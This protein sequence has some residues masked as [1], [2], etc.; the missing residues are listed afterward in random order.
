MSFPLAQNFHPAARRS[1]IVIRAPLGAVNNQWDDAMMKSGAR[2]AAPFELLRVSPRRIQRAASGH[3]PHPGVEARHGR[4]SAGAPS[5]SPARLRNGRK[6]RLLRPPPG[7]NRSGL[8][9]VRRP[10]RKTLTAPARDPTGPCGQ[11]PTD[12]VAGLAKR[13]RLGEGERP[14]R[15]CVRPSSSASVSAGCSPPLHAGPLPAESQAG[16][17]ASPAQVVPR[18]PSS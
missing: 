18:Q 5:G 1:R 3:P 4:R 14:G 6:F 15:A 8:R 12:P 2:A 7:P 11:S 16:A 10:L 13:N 9:K 17:V